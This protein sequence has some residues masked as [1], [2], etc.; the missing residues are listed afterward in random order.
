MLQTRPLCH[1][2]VIYSVSVLTRVCAVE[3]FKAAMTDEVQHE[4]TSLRRVSMDDC[5][6]WMLDR[7]LPSH[8]HRRWL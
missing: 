1:R 2:Q 4:F 6:R 5:E 8:K 3:E 7:M